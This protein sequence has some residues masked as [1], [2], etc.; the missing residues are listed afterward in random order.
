MTPYPVLWWLFYKP[1]YYNWV[2]ATQ[3]FFIF[4]RIPGEDEPILTS[5]FQV[6]WFNH[7]LEKDR[8]FSHCS[9]DLFQWMNSCSKSKNPGWEEKHFAISTGGFW[10]C[11]NSMWIIGMNFSCSTREDLLFFFSCQLW[12]RLWKVGL[13]GPPTWGIIIPMNCFSATRLGMV[14]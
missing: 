1:L 12:G 7:Q 10:F 6:G 3:I 14:I 11:P 2:V 8:P 9:V 13:Y 5:I 4:T